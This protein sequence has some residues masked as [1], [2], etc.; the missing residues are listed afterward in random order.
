MC[1]GPEEG[2]VRK[3][4]W[5]WEPSWECRLDRQTRARPHNL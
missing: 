5:G 1:K 3:P 2:N 4:E